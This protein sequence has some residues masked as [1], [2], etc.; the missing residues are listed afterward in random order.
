M[1]S[2][3]AA[4]A[5]ASLVSTAAGTIMQTSGQRA[6]AQ[7]SA[8][9]LRYQAQVAAN[10]KIIADRAAADARKRGEVNANIQRQKSRQ[11]VGRQRAA[12]AGAGVVVDINSA[13]SLT[14]D[15]AGMGELDA[16]TVKSN[17]EREALGF[18]AK[19]MQ[20]GAEAGLK[21]ANAT[22]TLAAGNFSAA[23]TLVTGFG[24]VAD[25]WYGFKA[26]GAFK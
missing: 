13:L 2:W 10:N 22:N 21:R 5:I 1:G 8:N 6:S 24:S 17:A 11:L 3:T 18:Q 16:L 14:A 12:L 23:S 7:A 4:A 9:A 20:F 15:T 25:K 26:G 19:A